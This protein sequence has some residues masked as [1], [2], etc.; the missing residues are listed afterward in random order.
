MSS[1]ILF[2]GATPHEALRVFKC[3]GIARISIHTFFPKTGKL[4]R[5]TEGKR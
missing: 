2:A 1:A 3:V 5:N 4:T